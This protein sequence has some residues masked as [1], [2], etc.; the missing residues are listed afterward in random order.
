MDTTNERQ[1]TADLLNQLL[2]A[3][4]KAH[5]DGF[6]W[7]VEV[8]VTEDWHSRKWGKS[9][10]VTAHD[11]HAAIAFAMVAISTELPQ[12]TPLDA[13]TIFCERTLAKA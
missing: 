8:I 7:K 13:L 11:A 3:A 9:L 1:E 10:L 2:R 12:P 4:G 6:Q 5:A